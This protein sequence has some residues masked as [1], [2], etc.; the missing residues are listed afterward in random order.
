MLKEIKE[1][2]ESV[3]EEVCDNLC[4]Y[5]PTADEDSI[6]DYIREHGECPLDRLLR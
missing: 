3:R 4:Q 1:T 2:I 5:A 6:C